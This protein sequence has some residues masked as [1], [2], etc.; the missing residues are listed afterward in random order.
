MGSLEWTRKVDL[1]PI[2]GCHGRFASQTVSQR[3]LVC[4]ITKGARRL[5][6]LCSSQ[7]SRSPTFEPQEGADLKHMSLKTVTVTSMCFP[8]TR[9]FS[10]GG[11][12]LTLGPNQQVVW[13]QR[14]WTHVPPMTWWRYRPP[15][16]GGSQPQDFMRSEQLLVSWTPVSLRGGG[17]RLGCDP[18]WSAC[19]L[20]SW[21]GHILGLD[22]MNL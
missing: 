17:H 9:Q 20:H 14:W 18:C 15:L 10:P 8:G 5:L 19:P 4:R 16:A 6:P 7:G 2:S 3:P 12:R 21:C 1:S 11:E 13:C 22:Q